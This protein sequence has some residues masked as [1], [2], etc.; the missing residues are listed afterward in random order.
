MKTT[1]LLFWM[2]TAPNCLS[3]RTQDGLWNKSSIWLDYIDYM[4]QLNQFQIFVSGLIHIRI[5][6][7]LGVSEAKYDYNYNYK[8]E[9]QIWRKNK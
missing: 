2:M 5:L 9:L 3:D 6:R 8:T 1:G 4:T 7:T